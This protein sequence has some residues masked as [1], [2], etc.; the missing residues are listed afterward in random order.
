MAR[1]HRYPYIQGPGGIPV[2]G[3]L[4]DFD[5]NQETGFS[6]MDPVTTMTDFAAI[7]PYNVPFISNN[8]L[9]R[10][11][12]VNSLPT[13][14]VAGN[15]QAALFGSGDTEWN[16]TDGGGYTL[17]C[18]ANAADNTNNGFIGSF[19]NNLSSSN[20]TSVNMGIFTD[21]D[22]NLER[23]FLAGVSTTGTLG[24]RIPGSTGV[25][26][27]WVFVMN[28]GGTT[29]VFQNGVSVGTDL[30]RGTLGDIPNTFVNFFGKA[31]G[32]FEEFDGEL[33]RF[34]IYR[35]GLAGAELTGLIN[36]FESIY[37]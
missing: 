31:G 6:D 1:I 9:Y 7:G 4:M 2:D 32:G 15:A 30:V 10:T 37:G 28:P 25:F 5:P 17:A 34:L 21:N 3:L 35:V 18:V 20:W 8:A 14:Q 19:I 26:S 12:R 36:D 11:N 22:V 16:S 23:K 24:V 29:E 27:R 13:F 33:A